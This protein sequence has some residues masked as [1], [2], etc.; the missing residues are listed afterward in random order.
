MSKMNEF[1]AILRGKGRYIPVNE[2]PEGKQW[3]KSTVNG[4]CRCKTAAMIGTVFVAP[5]DTG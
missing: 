2:S 3:W 1:E 5:D 4:K